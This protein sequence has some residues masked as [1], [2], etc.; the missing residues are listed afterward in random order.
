MP[1]LDCYVANYWRYH[2]LEYIEEKRNTAKGDSGVKHLDFE[3][4]NEI[5]AIF[6]DAMGNA[7]K[8][9][10]VDRAERLEMEKSLKEAVKKFKEPRFK[11]QV[12]LSHQIKNYAGKA[13]SS[14]K[15]LSGG[16]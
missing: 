15:L 12:W 4:A 6:W 13:V 1:I 10:D 11:L 7:S 5:R 3:Q 14:V 2:G 16:S 9:S 8:V